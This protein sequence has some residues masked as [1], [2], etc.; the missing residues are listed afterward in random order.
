MVGSVLVEGGDSL[1]R[2]N[3]SILYR[4]RRQ[5]AGG[6]TENKTDRQT[7][8]QTENEREMATKWVFC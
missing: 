6:K 1:G 3:P 7:D 2:S 5:G 8:R 4:E